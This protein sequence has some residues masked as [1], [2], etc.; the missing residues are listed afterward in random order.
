MISKFKSAVK[1]TNTVAHNKNSNFQAT[2]LLGKVTSCVFRI[3]YTSLIATTS[4]LISG[5]KTTK[6]SRQQ[7]WAGN[8]LTLSE[9]LSLWLKKGKLVW[10]RWRLS[11]GSQIYPYQNTSPANL[12]PDYSIQTAPWKAILEVFAVCCSK[13]KPHTGFDP[14]VQELT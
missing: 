7:F 1:I 10:P 4:I 13:D 11:C 9:K 8:L 6:K 3:R 2:D 12:S 14:Y 5:K